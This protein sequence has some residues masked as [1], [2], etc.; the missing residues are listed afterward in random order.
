MIS[1]VACGTGEF[2]HS[3][4]S[5]W[6]GRGLVGALKGKLEIDVIFPFQSEDRSS[7]SGRCKLQT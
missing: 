2:W 3:L 5:P 4:K 7:L 6:R 1:D